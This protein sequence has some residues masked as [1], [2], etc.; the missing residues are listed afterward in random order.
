MASYQ[1]IQPPANSGFGAGFGQG[2]ATG[3]NDAVSNYMKYA[4]LKKFFPNGL[5]GRGG[6]GQNQNYGKTI[7]SVIGGTEDPSA[8]GDEANQQMSENYRAQNPGQDD[9]QD[10]S[11]NNSDDANMPVTDGQGQEVDDNSY[12]NTVRNALLKQYLPGMN[13]QQVQRK[14]MGMPEE[15]QPGQ[16]EQFTDDVKGAMNGDQSWDDVIKAHPDK[17]EN[18]MR[19]KAGLNIAKGMDQDDQSS[20]S[21]SEDQSAGDMVSVLNPDGIPGQI[22]KSNLDAAL[23][24]G[25]KVAQ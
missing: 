9:M 15:K 13:M 2:I 16:A 4:M 18:I 20:G 21:E 24:R 14:L 7:A 19:I 11:D 10:A 8:L 5:Y 25:F 1:V 12:N 3:T 23:K 17:V 6:S 22:P